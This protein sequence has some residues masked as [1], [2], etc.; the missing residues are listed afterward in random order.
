MWTCERNPEP[1]FADCDIEQEFLDD[2][3]DRRIELKTPKFMGDDDELYEK[4]K[5]DKLL[6]RQQRKDRSKQ[7]KDPLKNQHSSVAPLSN[8]NSSID[9][10][11]VDNNDKNNDDDDDNDD[12]DSWHPELPVEVSIVC[13]DVLGEYNTRK[14]IIRCLCSKCAP[15]PDA[16][17][18]YHAPKFYEAHCGLT[19]A[20]KWKA[21]IRV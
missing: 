7:R 5:A 14:N 8:V 12:D 16:L 2:E 10:K 4:A 17:P 20:R 1:R 3:I 9:E 11:K 6:K 13:R 18:V 21:S 15:T 19:Q